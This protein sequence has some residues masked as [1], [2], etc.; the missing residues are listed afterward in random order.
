MFIILSSPVRSSAIAPSTATAPPTTPE[1]PP[2]GVTEILCLAAIFMTL[3]TSSVVVGITTTPGQCGTRPSF[4]SRIESGHQSRPCCARDS[5]EMSNE[6]F[7][8]VK[9]LSNAAG[10][11]WPIASVCDPAG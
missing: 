8:A 10:A 1:R 3:E 7:E 2:C 11:L 4:T 5:V 6:I 9:S